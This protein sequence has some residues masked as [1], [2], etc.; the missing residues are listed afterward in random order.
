MLLVIVC[1]LDKRKTTAMFRSGPPCANA[2]NL[3]LLPL[4]KRITIKIRRL[5]MPNAQTIQCR[6]HGTGRDP[7]TRRVRDRYYY[8]YYY[9]Y[10]YSAETSRSFVFFPFV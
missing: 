9:Y 2:P 6:A 7:L 1:K 5:Y 4:C 8:Y 3:L 10:Y